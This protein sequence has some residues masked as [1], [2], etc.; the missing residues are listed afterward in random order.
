MRASL[1]Y[2]AIVSATMVTLSSRIRTGP[3]VA[4]QRSKAIRLL[5][6]S[7]ECRSVMLTIAEGGSFAGHQAEINRSSAGRAPAAWRGRD[8]MSATLLLQAAVGGVL[9]GGIYGLLAMGLSLSWGLLKLVNL[10]HFALA[11]LGAYLTY[12]LGM[13][14]GLPAWVS[15]LL[16]VPLFFVFGVALH[17]LFVTFEVKEFAS[18]LVTF[19][20]TI[21]IESMIQWIW[22]ADF[23]RYETPLFAEH[24]AR[25]PGLHPGPRPPGVRLRAAD[26]GGGMARAE[27]DHDRKG[28]ARRGA[29]RPGRRRLRRELG[30]GLLCAR[31]LLLGLGRGRRRLHR[32]D[33]DA[34]AVADRGMDRRGLR[35]G[36]HR[37]AREP[38]RRPRGRRPGRGRRSR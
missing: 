12:Q 29:G 28:A 10:S 35:G 34:G 17:A 33:H 32:A 14:F 22:S 20:I 8:A 19:G 31:R 7:C 26:R 2:F 6:G 18:L 27:P 9:L 11:F 38:A 36:D 1:G 5:T 24:A 3:S 21:L 15:G 13:A 23:L 37:R 4:A 16:I 25:R 30:A